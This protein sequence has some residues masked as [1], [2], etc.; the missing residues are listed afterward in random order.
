M[1]LTHRAPQRLLIV[2]GGIAGLS[3]A[4]ALHRAR[5]E[6]RT[7]LLEQAPEFSEIG[8]GLQLGPNAVRVLRDWGLAEAL[9]QVAAF[10]QRLMVRRV[11]DGATLGTLELGAAVQRRYGAPYATVHRADLHALLLHALQQQPG[12]AL[13]T[14]QAVQ[15]LQ[16]HGDGV[17]ALGADEQSWE[18]DAALV[19]DGVWSRL[20]VQLLGDGAPQFSGHVA[21]RGL[22]P[23]DAVPVA[24]ARDAVV[25]WLGPRL[26]GVHYPV[27][28][29]Q[30]LNA[31]LVIEGPMPS[32]DTPGWD[33]AAPRA[34]L[35]QTLQQVHPDLG[36]IVEAMPKWRQ[37][38]L[39]GRAP[40]RGP[41]EHAQGRVGLLGD[42]AHPM[43]PYLA[44][45]A[46]MA[47]ED[48][49]TLAR[50]LPAAPQPI[51]W[52]AVLRRWAEARWARN[53][54][55][56]ARSRRNGVIFHAT[57]LLRWGRDAALALLGRRLLDQPWL[58]AGPPQPGA[59]G[60]QAG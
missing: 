18:A 35:L 6:L 45:G 60:L 50:L 13:Y 7:T 34:L 27:R 3:A 23:M 16:V 56:Q 46:A 43:R 4:L 59:A 54:R 21:Y 14:G 32:G 42:A 25:A 39:F 5:P 57:G 58:Y 33:H 48:A 53:A 22:L 12:V 9:A 19:A 44:Q 26:H 37:W 41:H 52:P 47:L 55:V 49:W 28:G 10:P 29:G 51:D 2:G 38:P 36:A 40:M 20:R 1:A 15:R 8:A 17:R 31:V 11:A 24:L 30:W